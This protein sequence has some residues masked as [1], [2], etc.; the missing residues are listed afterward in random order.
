MSCL[1]RRLLQGMFQ[2]L[3]F[4]GTGEHTKDLHSVKDVRIWFGKSV[5]SL[6]KQTQLSHFMSGYAG[7]RI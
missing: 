4:V 5:V 1:F 6:K 3:L 7:I 2:Y